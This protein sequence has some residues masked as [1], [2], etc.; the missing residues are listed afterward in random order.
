MKIESTDQD[1]RTL[2]SSTYY[3]IPRFQR[4]YSWEREN[5]EEFWDDVVKDSNG[6]YFIGSMVVYKD[7]KRYLGI[8][9]GQ[10][11]L[12]TITI[13]L[14]VLR[15][16]FAERGFQDLAEGIHNLVERKNIDN[17]PEFIL[18]TESSHPFFQD[19]IQKWGEPELSVNV[20]KE[21]ENLQRAYN[22]LKNLVWGVVNGIMIDTSKSGALKNKL[23]EKRLKEIRA[24]ILD[25]KLIL[26]QLDNEDDAYLIFETL[27]TRGKNLSVTDLVKNHLTKHLKST[28]VS[29]DQTK[30]KWERILE[31]IES[32][33]ADINTDTFIHHFWLSKYNYL[34]LKRLFKTLRKQIDKAQAKDFLGTLVENSQLYR[35]IHEPTYGKWSKQEA[36]VEE[37]LNAFLLFKIRQQTP[38]VLSLVRAYKQGYVPKKHLEGALVAI[39][40]FHFS[41]TAITSQ[42]SSGGISAMYASLARRLSETANVQESVIVIRELK[43]KLRDRIPSIEEFKALFPEVIYTNNITK[44]RKLVRYILKSFHRTTEQAVPVDYSQMT[45][46]HL[47][48][49]SRIGEQGI[50]DSLVG[51]IGNMI[52]IPQKLNEKLQNKPFDQ[53]KGILLDAGVTLSDDIVSAQEWKEEQIRE[54]TAKMAE[55]AYKTIWRI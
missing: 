32:S 1:V 54:R 51:Q 48:P 9:D 27:N 29:V 53:K 14:C 37:A 40:K 30:I 33:S 21:E 12:T 38:C 45:I 3:K 5:V 11:R 17:K 46:E 24:Q 47:M 49:Q 10:Q 31:T 28:S 52:L 16:T 39:E 43:G 26:I 25:L 35:T 13:L 50:D 44:Q 8:V 55:V 23:L 6:D 7:A 18:S 19:C 4:P 41:F 15:D 22:Q 42:R 2:L 20:L 36:R 34:P